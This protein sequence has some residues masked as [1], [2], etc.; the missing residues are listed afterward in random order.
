VMPLPRAEM[1]FEE[2]AVLPVALQTMHDALVTHGRVQPGDAVLIQGASSGVGLMGL[3]VAKLMGAT[4]V[5]GTSSTPSRRER[6]HSHG[7]DLT[8]D[9]STD[10]WPQRVLDTTGGRG[11]GL[12]VDMLAGRVANQNLQAAAVGARIVNVGRLAGMRGEFDF[13]LHALKRIQYIGVTFRTRTV[14]EVREIVE[15]MKADLWPALQAG[16]LA[17]PIDRVFN[18]DDAAQALSHM[19]SN[20]HFGKIAL[21]LS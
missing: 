21:S 12:I 17:L 20:S 15:R 18:F 1:S 14:P 13:D 3:Q 19:G 11:V 7:A 4:L 16:K 9:S 10:H 8:L 5:I 2:A 6:L